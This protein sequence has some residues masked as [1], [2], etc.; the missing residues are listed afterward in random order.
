MIAKAE[1]FAIDPSSEAIMAVLVGKAPFIR[2][3]SGNRTHMASVEGWNFT[4]K[5]YPQ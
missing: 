5:L 4:T 3:G 2:A 1:R